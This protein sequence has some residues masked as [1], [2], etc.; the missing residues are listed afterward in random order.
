VTF[1]ALKLS[2]FV[3]FRKASGLMCDEVKKEI[4]SGKGSGGANW[5]S[6]LVSG[7]VDPFNSPKEVIK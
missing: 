6:P 2:D 4:R 7:I 3:A 1:D 5:I